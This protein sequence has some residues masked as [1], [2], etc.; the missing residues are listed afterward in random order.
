MCRNIT[1]GNKVKTLEC[2]STWLERMQKDD[3]KQ[4]TILSLWKTTTPQKSWQWLVHYH[5]STSTSEKP[6]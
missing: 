1:H 5:Y 6:H 2:T 3:S 4:R